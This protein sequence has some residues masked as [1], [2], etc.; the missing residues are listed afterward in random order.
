MVHFAASFLID[1]VGAK[2]A[3]DKGH[4]LKSEPLEGVNEF[5]AFMVQLL[6]IE[7]EFGGTAMSSETSDEPS[8]SVPNEDV[9]FVFFFPITVFPLECGLVFQMLVL[10]QIS[11]Q[12]LDAHGKEVENE[13]DEEYDEEYDDEDDTGNIDWRASW[14]MMSVIHC[15]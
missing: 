3:I 12:V 15:R 10:F 6:E 5:L 4:D 7:K 9:P 14:D 11:C 1:F 13:Y 8:G 2:V